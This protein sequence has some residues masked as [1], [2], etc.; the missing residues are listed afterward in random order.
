MQY[1]PGK[2]LR[3]TIH[4]SQGLRRLELAGKLAGEW[5]AET[6]NAFKAAGVGKHAEV[7][8]TAV[9]GVDET[10]EAEELRHKGNDNDKTEA[11]IMKDSQDIEREAADLHSLAYLL[12]GRPDVSID[13]AADAVVSEEGTDSFFA[14]WMRDWRRRLVI[15]KALTA[16]RDELNVSARRTKRARLDGST[17]RRDWSTRPDV[18]K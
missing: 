3:I 17:S 12:T 11:G 2:M 7:D 18:T 1:W 14:G 8:L 10:E 15:G 13:I 5:V 6:E 4:D 9:T 16:V